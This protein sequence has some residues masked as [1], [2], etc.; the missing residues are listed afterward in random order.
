MLGKVFVLLLQGG[1]NNFRPVF[2]NAG[3]L[4]ILMLTSPL[5][6]VF[7][8]LFYLVVI[9]AEEEFEIKLNFNTLIKIKLL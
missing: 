9:L 3:F 5:L 1:M 7:L 6:G 4:N 8:F 2:P